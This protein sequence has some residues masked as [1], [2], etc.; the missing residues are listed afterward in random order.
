MQC[1]VPRQHYTTLR[2][3]NR[4]SC[5]GTNAAALCCTHLASTS[6]TQ[7]RMAGIRVTPGHQLYS[8]TPS[9]QKLPAQRSRKSRTLAE[10]LPWF[11]RHRRPLVPACSAMATLHATVAMVATVTG[12]SK[13]P[14]HVVPAYYTYAY[15]MNIGGVEESNKH[16][17]DTWRS[18]P[19]TPKVHHSHGQR[20]G[21]CVA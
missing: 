2:Q 5:S 4:H 8:I 7:T 19:N 10:S 20:R 16:T 3:N 21:C 14:A 18:K 15:P 12:S 13:E 11:P 17:K 1:Y 6:I 9:H